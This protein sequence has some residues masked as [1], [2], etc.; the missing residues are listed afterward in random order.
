[1]REVDILPLIRRDREL[2][3][4]CPCLKKG[5]Y[6]TY[7]LETRTFSQSRIPNLESLDQ[8]L[9]SREV[10]QVL[11]NARAFWGLQNF[12]FDGKSLVIDQETESIESDESLADMEMPIHAAA[13]LFFAVVHVK[14]Q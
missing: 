7:R 4:G 13:E 14:S 12:G 8:G 3:E 2:V 10:H 9:E 11:R 5:L 1:M 6:S